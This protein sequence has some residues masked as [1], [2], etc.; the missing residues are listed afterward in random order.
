VSPTVTST[1]RSQSPPLF[2]N[3]SCLPP[4]DVMAT[5]TSG[6]A[7][8]PRPRRCLLAPNPGGS[9]LHLLELNAR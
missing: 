6:E 9:M 8:R 2:G 7:D 5:L 1:G 3:A 4:P